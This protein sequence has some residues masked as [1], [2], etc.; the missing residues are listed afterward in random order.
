MGGTFY[1]RRSHHGRPAGRSVGSSGAPRGVGDGGGGAIG[2]GVGVGVT[3]R[4]L[5]G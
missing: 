3:G 2:V 4:E 5:E 1:P